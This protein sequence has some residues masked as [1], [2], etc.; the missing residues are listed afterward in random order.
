YS[1]PRL[2]PSSTR[3]PY[4]TLFR[5]AGVPSVD[6]AAVWREVSRKLRTTDSSSSSDALQDVFRNYERKLEE[7]VEN[8]PAPIECNG[9]VFVIGDRKSTRLN[10]SHVSISYAV[11]C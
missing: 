5:S 3:F 9:A 11:C 2:P 7:S 10:S 1:I 6:Q 8:L 4:T